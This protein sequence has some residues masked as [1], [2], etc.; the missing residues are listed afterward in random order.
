MVGPEHPDFRTISDVRTLHLAACREVL[1]PVLRIAGAAGRVQWGTLATDGTNLQ[2][3]AS[4]HTARR[5]GARRKEADRWREAMAA[6]V[7]QAPQ[8]DAAADAA[9]GRR[10]GD[11]V[12]AEL[13]R[14]ADRWATIEAAMRR[15][16]ARA[17][18]DAEAERPR[19]A[20]VDAARPRLGRRRRGKAPTPVDETPDDTAQTNC[21]APEWPRLRTN[22]QGWESGGKAPA[23][24]DAASQ[25]IVACD[26]TTE[27][28]DTQHAEP[29]A[30][31]TAAPL[32]PAGMALPPDAT[33]AAPKMPATSD[34]GSDS[35]AAA[36][37]VEPRGFE[38]SMA[39]GRQRHHAS[40]AEAMQPPA[41]ATAR[42]AA[43]VRTPTGRALYAR[44]TGIVEP[45][46][47]QIKAA[48][49]FRRFLWRGLDN[50][51]GEGHLV[52]VTHNLL[53]LWRYTCAPSTVSSAAMAPYGP[54]M[55]LGKVSCRLCTDQVHPKPTRF[56]R[57]GHSVRTDCLAH[58]GSTG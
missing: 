28:N 54:A 45:V 57:H 6:L 4:R 18:A 9:L 15:L 31:L 32:E 29:M 52:C 46:G 11:E 35:A 30:R 40:A 51:R 47:G 26:V 41:T 17:K 34:R 33:G 7:T 19:R 56:Q 44:R 37:A 48:R 23:R 36:A 14:R 25:S 24:V 10:R 2:G 22:N 5:S 21:T 58:Q 38:P 43:Q 8:P 50:I 20:A 49:G 27:A 1:V 13:A 53:K 55:A 3:Q 39:T 16:E 42:M 12:P